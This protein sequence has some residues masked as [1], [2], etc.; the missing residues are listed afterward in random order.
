MPESKTLPPVTL[1]EPDPLKDEATVPPLSEKDEADKV[2]LVKTPFEIIREVM[3]SDPARMSWPFV[4]F[5][6][7]PALR[8][9]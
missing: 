6:L 2:P 3:V 8:I 4:M 9:P 1:S 5:R 7:E